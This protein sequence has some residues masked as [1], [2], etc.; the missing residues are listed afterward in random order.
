MVVSLHFG[1][2]HI[3][4]KGET[5][6]RIPSEMAYDKDFLVVK[7]AYIEKFSFERLCLLMELNLV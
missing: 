7:W 3:F 1:V 2:G 6:V 5:M 4:L